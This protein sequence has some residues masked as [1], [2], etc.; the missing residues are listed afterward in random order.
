[1]STVQFVVS[2]LKANYRRHL[3]LD[4]LALFLKYL[5]D[6]AVSPLALGAYAS[7]V[8]AWV[9]R[10]WIVTGPRQRAEQI[11]SRF[12]DDGARVSALRDLLGVAPPPGLKPAEIM[13]WVR[14]RSSE[15][16]HAYLIVAYLATLAA[17]VIVFGMATYGW[18]NK[19]TATPIKKINEIVHRD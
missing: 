5:G 7:A 3:E 9:A 15:R 19:N 10:T 2:M 8:A 4:E 1:L 16:A 6:A 13:D 12:R 14:V 11:V 17:I 18:Y